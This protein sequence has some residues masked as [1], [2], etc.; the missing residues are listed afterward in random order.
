MDREQ[1]SRNEALLRTDTEITEPLSDKQPE[2]GQEKDKPD[3][4]V[5]ITKIQD[6]LGTMAKLF[7][8]IIEDKADKPLQGDRPTGS[9]KRP[10]AELE[11]SCDEESDSE[12]AAFRLRGKRQ[13][14]EK[15]LE[16]ITIHVDDTED[17]VAKLLGTD[18]EGENVPETEAQDF[19]DELA[20][21][22]SDDESTGPNISP[23]LAD[24]ALKRWGKQMNAEKLKSILD[25]YARP[26][27][28]PGMTCKKVNPEIW[29]LL[30]KSRKRTDVQFY[31]LQ[32]TVLKVMFAILQT[33]NTLVESSSNRGNNQI[34]TNL[35]D[36]IA[37]LAHTHSNISLLRKDQIKPALKNEYSAICDLEE[38]PDSKLLF[39]NELAKN[40][41]E[42][43]EASNLSFSMK[44][45]TTKTYSANK[46]PVSTYKQGHSYSNKNFLCQ[47]QQRNKQRKKTPWKGGQEKKW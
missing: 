46:K 41:K 17:E 39:G 22:L 32:Q 37:M 12:T 35:I 23:K 26:E 25:K 33:T 20:K 27:N 34:L 2:E 11:D 7:E 28:C 4:H 9:Q 36:T 13:R 38:Q 30:N 43:K 15:S 44:S 10:S 8:R 5:A 14:R 3:I 45:F 21:G 16:A 40:L 47:G 19:L 42:A 18:K 1:A 31:H 29:K 24:I 6:S